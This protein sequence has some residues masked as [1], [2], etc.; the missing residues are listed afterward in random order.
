MIPDFGRLEKLLE[1]HCKAIEANT[2]EMQKVNQNLE[3]F[4]AD[5]QVIMAAVQGMGGAGA[6]VQALAPLRSILPS[7]LGQRPR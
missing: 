5:A 3:Q 4:R 1:R 6:L 7:L 2:A